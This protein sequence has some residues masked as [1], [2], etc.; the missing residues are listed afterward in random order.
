MTTTLEQAFR[1]EWGRVLATLIGLLGDF[2][3]A[4]E[5]AQEAFA[6]AAARW[7]RDGVP[8]NPRA[9]LIT[10]ARNR[11][12]DRIRR[13]RA[14]TARYA[15]LIADDHTGT[16]VRDTTFPD[17][18]L[19]LIFTC[20]HPALATDAQVAL[21]LRTL[22]GLTTEE[23]AR[24]FLV[25]AP[26]MAQRLVRAKRKIRA[27]GI[28]FRVPPAHLLRERLDAVL[29]VVYLIFNEGYGGRAEPAAE[30]IR[31]ARALAGLLPG[32]SEVH[33]LLALMLLHDSRRDARFRDGEIVLLEE[34]DRSLWDTARIA[35]GRAELESAL[36]RGGR[37]QYVLQAAIA[38]LHA[39]TP[40]DWPRIAGLYAELARLTG[41]PVVELNRA[42]AI[43]ET[44]GPEAGL[45]MI[46]Q[47]DLGDFRYLHAT[48][49]E[50]LRRL[51]RTGEA[52]AAYLR[53][54]Q[55]T[56]DGAERRFLDRRLNE[57]SVSSER[58]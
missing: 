5:A 32:D 42:I 22:G 17:E 53:A 57:L 38:A 21:T 35:E 25:A 14:L 26:A 40:C 18:R 36:E 30:A 56:G 2:D 39:E 29:A 47:I 6:I 43:A 7:P 19:E 10:T 23:I 11:A 51:G 46:D 52:R 45:H 12:T 15:R 48:R 33:G 54:R 31:L 55:L 1:E 4:E 16:P 58:S 24:A 3:L 37:G 8:G 28:P 20:C 34:Q 13:D 9:W 27:A 44:D 50:L 49:A 41:S